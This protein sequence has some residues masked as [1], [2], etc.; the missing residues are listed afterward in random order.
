[1]RD[2]SAHNTAIMIKEMQ[3]LY[4][5]REDTKGNPQRYRKDISYED[6]FPA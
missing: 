1:M 3:Y 5:R 2:V 6:R 4:P